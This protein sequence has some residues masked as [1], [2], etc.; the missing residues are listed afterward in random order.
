[1][2]VSTKFISGAAVALCLGVA[3]SAQAQS[4]VKIYGQLDLDVGRFQAAGANKNY[5]VG[6]GDMSTSYLGFGGKE[7]LGGGLSAKFNIETF[8]R[9]DTGRSGRVAIDA[10]TA[11]D[12]FWGRAANVG[13]T[14]TAGTVSLGRSTT[15]L[16]ISTIV[17]NPFGD[18]FG[19]SPAV[20]QYYTREII[21]DTSWSN[22]ITYNS[23]T[24][25]GFS[26]AVQANLGEGAAG[27][28]GKNLGANVLYFGGPFAATA[29]YQNVKNSSDVRFGSQYPV[30]FN[31]QTAYQFGAS[32]DLTVVKGYVQYGKVTTN[33]A[34]NVDAKLSQVGL[35]APLGGGA[36][37]ASYGYDKRTRAGLVTTSKITTV[38]YDYNLSKSTDIYATYVRDTVTNLNSGNTLAAGIRMKF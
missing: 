32:Y 17:F 23:P 18:S 11:T 8:F 27:T 14:S 38:G 19:F 2:A 12:V 15:G 28:K 5:Q 29:A 1:M 9:P 3:A 24:I 37:L 10:G 7:D 4:S 6:N 31:N 30:G 22:S 36:V 13:L 21:G 20:R 35:S 26:V 16:F 34:T 33:A 25:S